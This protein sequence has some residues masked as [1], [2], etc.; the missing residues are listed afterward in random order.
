M[1]IKN[2]GEAM[3]KLIAYS[4]GL[5]ALAFATVASASPP[6]RFLGR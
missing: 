1:T 2:E 5:A 4:I 6:R 3:K